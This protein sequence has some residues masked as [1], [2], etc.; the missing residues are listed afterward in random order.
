[1]F[2]ILINV[3]KTRIECWNNG[4]VIRVLNFNQH[5]YWNYNCHVDVVEEIY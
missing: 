1:M 3:L 2:K 5:E 4:H